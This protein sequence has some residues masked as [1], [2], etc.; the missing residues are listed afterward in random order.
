MV[1]EGVATHCFTAST[2]RLVSTRL[3]ASMPHYLANVL[4]SLFVRVKLHLPGAYQPRTGLNLDAICPTL[5]CV[6]RRDLWAAAE[7]HDAG[8]AYNSH[9]SFGPLVERNHYEKQALVH[10]SRDGL[11]GRPSGEPRG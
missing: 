2:T 7:V 10:Q 9:A 4:F 3:I 5:D 1:A 8:M 11:C 6:I